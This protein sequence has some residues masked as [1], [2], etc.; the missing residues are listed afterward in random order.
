MKFLTRKVDYATDLMGAI[1]ERS[2]LRLGKNVL[3]CFF[4]KSLLDSLYHINRDV[5]A[6][7]LAE[8]SENEDV[9]LILEKMIVT[10]LIFRPMTVLLKISST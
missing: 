4:Y 10:G 5:V 6:S 7:L 3:S 8:I 2:F 9:Y 1:T